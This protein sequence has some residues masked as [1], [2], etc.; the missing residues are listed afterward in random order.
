MRLLLLLA[1]LWISLPTSYALAAESWPTHSPQQDTSA[2]MQ[3]RLAVRQALLNAH[4]NHTVQG[5]LWEELYLRKLVAPT[6]DHLA[7]MI[8]FDSHGPDCGAPDCYSTDVSFA[9]PQPGPLFPTTLSVAVH[10][11]GC[12]DEETRQT[13][14]FTC[15]ELTA[16]NATY[17]S[18]ELK[19][20]LILWKTH[21]A[22]GSVYYYPQAPS[23]KL[24]AEAI[25]SIFEEGDDNA[26]YP[27][28][29]TRMY[30]WDYE[31]YWETQK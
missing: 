8:P 21:T 11:H 5:T 22:L 19:A 29:S 15:T 23:D 2:Y 25:R 9:V 3:E 18:A 6:T 17:Y 1:T 14:A 13:G 24:S 4:P 16:E 26:Y 10:E 30:L 31:R 20:Y 7:V 28:Q 27:Y 12:I